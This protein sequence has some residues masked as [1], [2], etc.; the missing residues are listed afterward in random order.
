MSRSHKSTGQQ[1]HEF[2]L[3][4]WHQVAALFTQ[5][6]GIKMTTSNAFETGKRAIAK[7]RRAVAAGKMNV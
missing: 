4:P 7:L 3:R 1:L 5:R 2:T 6:T